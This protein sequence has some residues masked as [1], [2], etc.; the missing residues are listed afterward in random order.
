M[1]IKL[2]IYK[3]ILILSIV[4]II[5]IIYFIYVEETFANKNYL[6]NPAHPFLKYPSDIKKFDN[7]TDVQKI[8]NIHIDYLSKYLN[9]YNASLDINNT[10]VNAS[11]KKALEKQM[12]VTDISKFYKY[13][14]YY[15]NTIRKSIQDDE[16]KINSIAN[17][18]ELSDR[19]YALQLLTGQM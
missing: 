16:K 1:I 8:L 12:L 13:I 14:I 17:Q 2:D 19:L 9:I 6:E 10:L 4:T 5:L 15:I 18:I 7:P 3:L 11:Y